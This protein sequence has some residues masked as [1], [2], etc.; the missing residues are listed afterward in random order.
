MKAGDWSMLCPTIPD[1]HLVISFAI[2]QMKESAG[3]KELALLGS[4]SGK[5]A[6]A[7]TVF[8]AGA[9]ENTVEAREADT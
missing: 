5:G 3:K 2:M 6:V 1:M 8:M 4:S 9:D 7:A